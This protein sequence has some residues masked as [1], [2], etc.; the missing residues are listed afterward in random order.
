[1]NFHEHVIIFEIEINK[2]A[3]CHKR[4]EQMWLITNVIEMHGVLSISDKMSRD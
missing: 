1:M 3:K 4:N 2:V